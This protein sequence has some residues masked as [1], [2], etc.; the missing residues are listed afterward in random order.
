MVTGRLCSEWRTDFQC[1]W[2]IEWNVV[3]SGLGVGVGGGVMCFVLMR[4]RREEI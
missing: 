3:G 1:E 4:K 2:R